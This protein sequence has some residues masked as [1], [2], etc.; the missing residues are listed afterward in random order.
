M[1]NAGTLLAA[2]VYFRRE[3][4]QAGLAT[5]RWI[6]HEPQPD[7]PYLLGL[8]IAASIPVLLIGFLFRGWF[9]TTARRPELIAATSI[10]FGVLLWWADRAGARTRELG[11]LSWRDSLL[12]GLAQACALIPGTSRSG[13]TITGGLALGFTREEAAHF[14]F[15]LAI[16]VGLAAFGRDLLDLMA[17]GLPPSEIGP[18]VIG[19]LVSA[20]SA[21]LVIG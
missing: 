6:R 1:T 5:W 9:E 2:V 18:L 4:W 13:V 21:Y 19:F 8:V 16:S 15:L 12:I 17:N 10:G 3:L 7:H 11:D 20:V 14:S